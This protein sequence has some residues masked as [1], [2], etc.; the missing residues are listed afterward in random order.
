[1][2]ENVYYTIAEEEYV[3]SNEDEL[4]N[5]VLTTVHAKNKF[6]DEEDYSYLTLKQLHLICDYYKITPY[7]RI[8]KCK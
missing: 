5:V 6:I 7:I 4:E 1:M 8:T 3:N 2:C